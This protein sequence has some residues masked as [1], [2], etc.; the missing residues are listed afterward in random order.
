ML[1]DELIESFPSLK[2]HLPVILGAKS[3]NGYLLVQ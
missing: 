3:E 1:L 2:E